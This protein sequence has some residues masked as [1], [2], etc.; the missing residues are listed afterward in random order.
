MVFLDFEIRWSN[1][2]KM[3]VAYSEMN[4]TQRHVAAITKHWSV[5]STSHVVVKLCKI[6]TEFLFSTASIQISLLAQSTKKREREREKGPV[7]SGVVNPRVYWGPQF[8]FT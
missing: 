8:K 4:S 5:P 2:E 7:V 6:N 1:R 3:H